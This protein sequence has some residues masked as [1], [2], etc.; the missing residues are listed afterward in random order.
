MH[1]HAIS[2]GSPF[3]WGIIGEIYWTSLS[4]NSS[5]SWIWPLL[6]CQTIEQPTCLEAFLTSN[7]R[8]NY[9]DVI[10]LNHNLF[11][12]MDRVKVNSSAYRHWHRRPDWAIEWDLKVSRFFRVWNDEASQ[13]V[14]RQSSF[15]P[16]PKRQKQLNY[17]LLYYSTVRNDFLFRV[18][19]SK[20]EIEKRNSRS[21]LYARDWK[22]EFLVLV[23]KNEI[24]IKISQ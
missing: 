21:R 3:F 4:G 14:G 9:D 8:L 11:W 23:S 10:K 2:E 6:T 18:L 24:F 13:N 17:I 1:F 20:H 22:K 19:V 7:F 16:S 5:F 12:S 15:P